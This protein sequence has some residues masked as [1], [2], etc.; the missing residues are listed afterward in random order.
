MIYNDLLRKLCCASGV[1]AFGT[2][3]YIHWST[4]FRYV[5]FDSVIRVTTTFG[6]YQSLPTIDSGDPMYVLST[7]GSLP[8]LFF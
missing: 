6:L 4:P 8:F 5:N 3:K 7:F 2:W 1:A